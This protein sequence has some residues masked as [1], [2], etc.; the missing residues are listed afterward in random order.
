LRDDGAPLP[1]G[2]AYATPSIPLAPMSLMARWVMAS[3]ALRFAP[4][5][6]QQ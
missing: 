2:S 4:K 5:L 1:G 6:A 3:L